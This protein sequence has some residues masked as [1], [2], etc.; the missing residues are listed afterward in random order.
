[1]NFSQSRRTKITD[2]RKFFKY[3]LVAVAQLLMQSSP[4]REEQEMAD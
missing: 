2:Q 4:N 1:M 3:H